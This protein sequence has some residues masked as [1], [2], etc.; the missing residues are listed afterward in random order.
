MP[1]SAAPSS[2]WNM[3][4]TAPRRPARCSR[5]SP[6]PFATAAMRWPRPAPG[7]TGCWRSAAGRGRTTGCRRSPPCSA[8][9]VMVPA[10]GDFGGAFGAARL[11][12]DGGDRGGGGDRH[13]AGDR[14]H[15][16]SGQRIWPAHIDEGHARYRAAAGRDQG[17][18]MTDF[19]D[20]I[21]KIA[22]EG[23][24]SDNDF[25]FRH[26]NPD[27]VVLGK[28]MEEHLRFAVAYW[29]SFAWPGG[30]P[31]GGQTFERPWFGDTMDHAPAEGRCRLRDVRHPRRAVL[32]LPRRRRA[33]RRARASP[34]CLRNLD[35]ITDHLRAR[36][37]RRSATR[38]L[39]GTANLFSHR[40]FMSGA[41]TNPDPE[42]F[43]LRRRR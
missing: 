28:R 27:E 3:P 43:A 17:A 11:A 18:D 8:P 35:A 29:H 22:Y 38:L 4:P 32:L 26:Y 10:A 33:P 7:S 25:A 20:G 21:A 12:I 9:P 39:W 16:R 37:W 1:L 2:A 30:D 6:S 23:A 14:A 41:A 15:H 24:D 42:V 34:K 5:A 19:F 36:R 31:F 40:R 13:H